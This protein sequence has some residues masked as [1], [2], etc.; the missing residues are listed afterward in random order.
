MEICDRCHKT[1]AWG[2]LR[3]TVRIGVA[4]DDGGEID[5]PIDA[6]EIEGL[7]SHLEHL[8]SAQLE[9]WIYERSGPIS[10]V[11][12]ANGSI[13]KIRWG[14]P[15]A[16]PPTG[17]T[18]IP[19]KP[20][21]KRPY[22]G[23]PCRGK[24]DRGKP[25]RVALI[26]AG[27]IG[28]LLEQDP[29]RGKPCTHAGAYDHHP[30]TELVAIAD[31]DKERRDL[32]GKLYGVR[33]RYDD[34]RKMLAEVRPD[35]V[36]IATWTELHSGMVV[37]ACEAGAQ[38]IYCE[39]PISAN[40]K[41][42]RRAVNAVAKS[43]AKMVVGHERRW[44]PGFL[45]L[46]AELDS[47]RLGTIRTMT[48]LVL[49]SRWPKVP[50]ARYGGGASFHDGTHMTD[51]FRMYAGEA[52]EV[53]ATVVREWGERSIDNAVHATIRFD[54]GVVG[55]F[56]AGDARDYFHFELDIQT[57]IARAVIGNAGA[58]LFMT[59]TS[60]QFT[61]FRELQPVAFPTLPDAKN[62]FIGAVDDL[63]AQMETDVP[64]GSSGEDG[65]RAA[66]MIFAMY[67]SGATNGAP[68]TLPLT[69]K[70]R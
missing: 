14:K 39:K 33:R 27:R 12:N 34:Y 31:I 13:L 10:S 53:R 55:T 66:E 9:K 64:S 32:V 57:D 28:A 41:D 7:I 4:V 51:L 15:P 37:A 49:S 18:T 16:I 17:R 52:V 47:G 19:S 54:S 70:R 67:K 36:S 63:I 68:V 42:A 8:E 40:L 6:A 21:R 59:D 30:R 44:S 26:G 48:G 23:K 65:Y 58:K 62:P 20:D 25:Y 38:G 50:R 2:D 69:G 61:G 35:I 24:P 43:G 60:K 22:R 29:L 5:R 45:A 11:Q 3:Y 1:I 46:K 56:V